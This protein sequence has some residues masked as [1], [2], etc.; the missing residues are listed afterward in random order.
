[1][2]FNLITGL[3]LLNWSLFVHK[4]IVIGA[5]FAATW[6]W[7]VAQT[8][9]T[10]LCQSYFNKCAF[11]QAH[12]VHSFSQIR[13]LSVLNKKSKPCTNRLTSSSAFWS[14][15][16]SSKSCQLSEVSSPVYKSTGTTHQPRFWCLCSSAHLR[17]SIHPSI[18]PSNQPTNQVTKPPSWHGRNGVWH[19]CVSAAQSIHAWSLATSSNALLTNVCETWLK[20]LVQNIMRVSKGAGA[21][22]CWWLWLLLQKTVSLLTLQQ[23]TSFFEASN[24]CLSS[25]CST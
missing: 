20:Y 19:E 14:G 21:A 17:C 16:W 5:Q 23:A 11:S 3:F 25:F 8:V 13:Q 24:F 9:L 6:Y 12:R 10:V 22:L 1:M 4:I 18:H 15:R 2:K 7:N